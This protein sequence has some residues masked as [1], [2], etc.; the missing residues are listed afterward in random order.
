MFVNAACRIAAGDLVHEFCSMTK[1]GGLI[2]VCVSDYSVTAHDLED[3]FH[4][5]SHDTVRFP[6]NNSN[7]SFKRKSRSLSSK[8]PTIMSSD[9][10]SAAGVP[11]D[12]YAKLCYYLSMALVECGIRD[13][14]QPQMTDFQAAKSD[15]DKEAI[16]VLTTGKQFDMESLSFKTVFLVDGKTAGLPDDL[17]QQA[18]SNGGAIHVTVE[19]AT[20]NNLEMDPLLLGGLIPVQPT[21][22]LLCTV[23]W[24]RA[25]YAEPIR[26]L[27]SQ[28]SAALGNGVSDADIE[29]LFVRTSMQ[30]MEAEAVDM[31]SKLQ[32]LMGA[33]QKVQ[34]PE[35]SFQ[36]FSGTGQS[37]G[38]S[39]GSPQPTDTDPSIFDPDLLPSTPPEIDQTTPSTSIAV[40]L[41]NG[42]RKV[43]K[44]NVQK[45]TVS[46]LAA[47]L[48]EESAILNNSQ[49]SVAS[50]RRNH[51]DALINAIQ[52]SAAAR[53]V[54]FDCQQATPQSRCGG[55][56]SLRQTL[57]SLWNQLPHANE[58][59]FDKI[60]TL[61][62]ESTRF[63]HTAVH[64][65]ELCHL[66]QIV[67]ENAPNKSSIDEA[68]IWY[69]IFFHDAIYNPQSKSNEE[70]SEKLWKEYARSVSIQDGL[71]THV[72]DFILATKQHKVS[73]D[74]SSSLALFLDLDMAVLG[75]AEDAYLAY[76]A[77]VRR[78]YAFVPHETY[79][80][81]R[82]KILREFLT[83]PIYGSN[84]F[85]EALE[86]RARTNL[87][88]E[89]SLLDQQ[90]I[91]S[92]YSKFQLV[93]GFPPK[94]L[95]DP[96]ATVEEAGLKG[97]QVSMR[98][99]KY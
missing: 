13:I 11:D 45:S 90:K 62:T 4:L 34:K 88:A 6:S 68:A 54:S 57:K 93:S 9:L 31:A 55:N 47:H 75:K 65:E 85:R 78:E 59:W 20:K 61:H 30:D 52:E 5:F 1:Q 23:E 27:Q 73:S 56:T 99:A 41:L 69:S 44:L 19:E 22:V 12:D 3:F 66:F 95:L 48:K 37:L 91:P 79:C 50:R 35:P 46:D 84:F 97:A 77:L 98:V 29:A 43:V 60:W 36:C 33:R 81:T 82:A 94:P 74:H 67:L 80:A 17:K 72:S 38:T 86:D 24:V 28:T 42:S 32:K 21:K 51:S 83:K 7:L 8:G 63:Y 58:E 71:Q 89:V 92:G 25:F 76:A 49:S 16:M 18:L 26:N 2:V 53:N 15:S 96:S 70:D 40:R 87:T 10:V 39:S 64:L 14:L